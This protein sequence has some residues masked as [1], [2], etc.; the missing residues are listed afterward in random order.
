MDYR[1]SVPVS[2]EIVI[3]NLSKKLSKKYQKFKKQRKADLDPL[4][5]YC[6]KENCGAEIIADSLHVE[7]VWCP[8]CETQVCFKCSDEWHGPEVTCEVALDKQLDDLDKR[9]KDCVSFC[10]VCRTRI[11]KPDKDIYATRG[12]SKKLITSKESNQMTCTFCKYQFCWVCGESATTEEKHFGI[13]RDCGTKENDAS[14][15][16]GDH[17]LRTKSDKRKAIAWMAFKIFVYVVFMPVWGLF[18]F[19]VMN[20]KSSWEGS[21]NSSMPCRLTLCFFA[22]LIGIIFSPHCLAGVIIVHTFVALYCIFYAIFYVLTCYH[23]WKKKP[24]SKEVMARRNKEQAEAN[25]KRLRI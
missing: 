13:W 11:Q 3:A 5:R 23:F 6:P 7:S 10:P 25:V 16:P 21:R 2:E 1:C 18:L 15:R 12:K 19:P 22:L 8:K 4:T 17:L 9:N 14:A 20:V 24:E